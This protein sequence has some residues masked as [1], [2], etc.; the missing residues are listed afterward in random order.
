MCTRPVLYILCNTIP[1]QPVFLFF[2][3][4]TSP[5]YELNY[6][7]VYLF[8]LLKVDVQITPGSHASEAAGILM[9]L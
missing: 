1:S 9:T 6:F 8:L 4:Q 2:Q 3:H 5:F 7:S